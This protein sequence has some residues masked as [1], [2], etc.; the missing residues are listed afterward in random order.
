MFI[1][2]IKLTS[3]VLCYYLNINKIKQHYNII[4]QLKV[5]IIIFFKNIFETIAV[6]LLLNNIL[7]PSPLET[8]SINN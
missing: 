4:I 2:L 6:N 8:H 3:I 5:K 1:G 7:Y